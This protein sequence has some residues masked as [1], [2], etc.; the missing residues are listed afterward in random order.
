MTSKW[1][2]NIC[3]REIISEKENGLCLE[4][5][6]KE[7]A[8]KI[9]I[10]P[11]TIRDFMEKYWFTSFTFKIGEYFD[12]LNIEAKNVK[13]LT[14]LQYCPEGLTTNYS[15]RTR[16]NIRKNF[17]E[18]DIHNEYSAFLEKLFNFSQ[19]ED[20]KRIRAKWRKETN[21]ALV[22]FKVDSIIIEKKTNKEIEKDKELL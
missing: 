4:C 17:Y 6:W 19:K 21:D 11:A 8:E 1:N 3:E 15:P 9:E 7:T 2:C 18:K 14:S 22:L 20:I 16:K 13:S 5:W 12:I 10:T